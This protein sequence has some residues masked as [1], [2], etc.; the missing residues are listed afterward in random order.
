MDDLAVLRQAASENRILVS[1]DKRTMPQA[2]A[3]LLHEGI[4]SPGIFLVIPQNAG[5]QRV[6]ESLILAWAASDSVEW[7]NRIT[8]GP[9]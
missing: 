8:K 7:K 5:I 3:T 4:E 2:F 6:S 1:H 9:F